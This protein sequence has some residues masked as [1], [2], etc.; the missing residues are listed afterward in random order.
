MINPNTKI[1][2]S[3]YRQ[4]PNGIIFPHFGE[5]TWGDLS[6][7]MTQEEKISSLIKFEKGETVSF[8]WGYAC[9]QINYDL[10]KEE[11]TV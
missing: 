5:T 7:V 10:I 2:I 1:R 6:K 3:G 4:L 8:S 11:I 9:G